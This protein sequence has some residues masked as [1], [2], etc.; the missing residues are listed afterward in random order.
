M[1]MVGYRDSDHTDWLIWQPAI[2]LSS[3]QST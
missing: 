2:K 1:E 3:A